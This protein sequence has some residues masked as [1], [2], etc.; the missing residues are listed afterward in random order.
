[1]NYIFVVFI[2]GLST[3]RII[4]AQFGGDGYF[5]LSSELLPHRSSTLQENIA[6][7]ITTNATDGVFFW[8]GQGSQTSGRGQDYVAI[9]VEDGHVV[10]RY[11]FAT[12]F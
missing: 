2:T 4:D 11:G 7:T 10:L 8:H 6:M 5:E 9:G 1:M 12:L 3:S